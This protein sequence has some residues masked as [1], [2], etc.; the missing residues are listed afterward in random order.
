MTKNLVIN[1]TD[2]SNSVCLA[3]HS[4]LIWTYHIY[5]IWKKGMGHV[6]VY[7]A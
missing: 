7:N 2:L 4:V 3:E 5:H 6:F 1:D